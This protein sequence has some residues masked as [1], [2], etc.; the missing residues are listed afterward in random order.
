MNFIFFTFKKIKFYS[1]NSFQ[2]SSFF[3]LVVPALLAI[4]GEQIF[5]L[6]FQKNRELS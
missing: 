4:L 1:I 6:A 3:F 2:L 5:G